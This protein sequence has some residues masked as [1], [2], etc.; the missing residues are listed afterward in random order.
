[1]S[2]INEMKKTVDSIGNLSNY[3][4][5]PNKNKGIITLRWR[6]GVVRGREI[7]GIRVEFNSDF[8]KENPEIDSCIRYI[9]QLN[10][11][12]IFITLFERV[13][14]AVTSYKFTQNKNTAACSIPMELWNCNLS[15]DAQYFSRNILPILK[16]K[17]SIQFSPLFW[18]DDKNKGIHRYALDISLE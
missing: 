4:V 16:Q 10:N 6:D 17:G 12:A 15:P 5:S 3:R 8:V 13:P 11:N 2:D 18:D 9:I 14:N 7:N 1:M